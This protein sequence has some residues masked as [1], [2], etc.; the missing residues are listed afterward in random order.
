MCSKDALR[1]VPPKPYGS[2]EIPDALN[3]QLLATHIRKHK[4]P[5]RPSTST[6]TSHLEQD[7]TQ[8]QS[9][10]RRPLVIVE[11]FLM[12]HSLDLASLFDVIVFLDV[13][14]ECAKTRRMAREEWLRHQPEYFDN[15]IWPAFQRHHA[16]LLDHRH[17]GVELPAQWRP[18]HDRLHVIDGTRSVTEV[19]ADVLA[20]VTAAVDHHQQQLQQQPD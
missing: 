4:T 20:I 5:R 15:E 6:T 14:L 17:R 9:A 8:H 13:D 7:T 2:W 11:G 1:M 12:L 19:G 10:S 3:L 18:I 16:W